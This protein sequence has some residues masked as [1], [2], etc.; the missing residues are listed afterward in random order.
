MNLRLRRAAPSM[1][2]FVAIAILAL[3]T[4]AE[5]WSQAY[6][7]TLNQRR[8]A[9]QL[10][11]EVWCKSQSASAPRLGEATLRI[12]YNSTYL[13][14]AD[15]TAADNNPDRTDSIRYDV[16]NLSSSS[17]TAAVVSI[18]SPFDP[19][20]SAPTS[21][22]DPT[23][24]T[25][26]PGVAEIQIRRATPLD[27]GVVPSMTGRG[28][29]V[30]KIVFDINAAFNGATSS[31]RDSATTFFSW[32][33]VGSVVYNYGGSLISSSDIVYTDPVRSLI[34]GLTIINPNGPSEVVDR[35]G[36]YFTEGIL[37]Y[38]IY[39]ER[40]GLSTVAT[41]TT[42]ATN[43]YGDEELAYYIDYRLSPA[44]SF[45][46]IGSID[47][48]GAV[49][50]TGTPL[51]EL[52][53]D[54]VPAWD[55]L[56]TQY[57]DIIDGVN[58]L[59]GTTNY[60]SYRHPLRAVWTANS[61][62]TYRSEQAQIRIRM[63]NGAGG[64]SGNA[65]SATYTAPGGDT[66]NY[67]FAIGR[68]FFQ[69]YSGNAQYMKTVDNYLNATEL[70]VEAWV[71]LNED[72]G[73]GTNPGIV[74]SGLGPG[75]DEGAWILYL[76]DGKYP[77]F[78]VREILGRDGGYLA[79]LV[80]SRS[81]N[82]TSDSAP[83]SATHSQNWHHIAATVSGNTVT[84]LVDGEIV[85]Y[86]QNTF[87]TNMRML[88]TTHPIWVGVNPNGAALTAGSYLH[89]GVKG[90]RV[91]RT[92]LL[93]T[94]IRE[95]VAGI[96]D[97]AGLAV[98]FTVTDLRKGLEY[99][100]D[101]EGRWNDLA[102]DA[103][104][105]NGT[106]TS[107][108]Y[109]N[110]STTS[111]PVFRP[112]QP[113]LRITAPT[114][115]AGVSNRS[116]QDFE[117]RWVGYGLGSVTG[118]GTPDGTEDLAIEFSHDGSTNWTLARGSAGALLADNLGY[119]TT[120]G[121]ATPVDIE[122]GSAV[123][124][125]Y[126]NN[127]LLPGTGFAGV[128]QNLQ[129]LGTGVYS[130]GGF[131]RIRGVNAFGQETINT[132][133][134][135]FSFA[136]YFSLQRTAASAYLKVPAG[137]DFNINSS[138]VMFEAWVRPYSFPASGSRYPI[139]AKVS[140]SG[141]IHYAVNLLST[142]QIEF[143]T[144][145]VNG[146]LHTA[147]S[148]STKPLVKPRTIADDSIWTHIAVSL[149]RSA[150]QS[151]IGFWIDGNLQSES[152][153]TNQLGLN[154]RVDSLNSF[155]AY[156]GYS[157]VSGGQRFIGE[158]REMRFWNGEPNGV[159]TADARR[160]YIQGAQSQRMGDLVP[161]TNLVAAF[162]MNGGGF[163]NGD[164]NNNKFNYT[165]PRTMNNVSSLRVEWFGTEITFV[166]AYPFMK[167]V[168]PT[169]NER[170]A[171]SVSDYRLR[172]V[173]FDYDDAS[174]TPGDNVLIIP[175]NLQ[176]SLGGGG[177]DFAQPFQ[178]VTSPYYA[179]LPDYGD[180]AGN[181][182][183]QGFRIVDVAGSVATGADYIFNA[184][185][186]A[187]RWNARN[188]DPDMNDDGVFADPGRISAVLTQARLRL[189]S[190]ISY[191]NNTGNDTIRAVSQ[192][193]TITPTSNFSVRV[194]LQGYHEGI[195][196]G[197]ATITPGPATA[198]RQLGS[199]YA[200][201]GLKIKLFSDVAGAP[202]VLI[203]SA[204]SNSLYH[205]NAF[206]NSAINVDLR[207]DANDGPLFAMVPFVFTS[208]PDGKY[209]VTVQHRNHL[210]AMS[211]IPAVFNYSGD[212]T[213]T[214]SL[215]SGWDFTYWDG[216]ITNVTS[217]ATSPNDP[218]IAN[219]ANRYS[220]YG[221]FSSSPIDPNWGITGLIYDEGRDGL[222]GVPLNYIGSMVAGDLN[223]DGWIDASDRVI[224]RN[225]IGSTLNLRSDVDG[226]NSVNASDRTIVDI[227]TGRRSSLYQI[228]PNLTGGANG[229]TPSGI[230]ANA[231]DAALFESMVSN[232]SAAL[233][234]GEAI[235]ERDGGLK[236]VKG[237]ERVLASN[238]KYTVSA[239]PKIVGDNVELP[240]YI[241]NQG[242]AFALANC[243]FTVKFNPDVLGFTSLTGS[244][245]VIF[246]NT[247]GKTHYQG[248]VSAPLE[249]TAVSRKDLRSI[250]ILFDAAVPTNKGVNVPNTKTYLGTLVFK[251]VRTDRPIN[252]TWD[253]VSVWTTTRQEV[254]GKGKFA[255]IPA[256][257]TYTASVVSPNGGERFA[258][259]KGRKTVITWNATSSAPVD[260]EFSQDG[261]NTW[262]RITV[263][264]IA[265]SVKQLNWTIPG[266]SSDKCLIRVVDSESG[267]EVDRSDATFVIAS[268]AAA[269]SRPSAADPIYVYGSTDNIK[270]SSQGV[271]KTRFEFKDMSKPESNWTAIT[272][273][274]NAGDGSVQWTVPANINT[275][276]AIIRMIDIESN[277]EIARTD[278]FKVLAG[279]VMFSYPKAGSAVKANGNERAR[280][281]VKN[282][283]VTFDLQF[284]A[285]GGTNWSTI[286]EKVNASKGVSDWTVPNKS[287]AK[288]ILRAI[289][290]YEPELEY[291]R[292]AEFAISGTTGVGEI[293]VGGL[294]FGAP[295]PN[296][297]NGIAT[298]SL[299]LPSPETVSLRVINTLGETVAVLASGEY[300]AAG[301]YNFTVSSGSLPAG[302]YT[303]RLDA[304]AIHLAQPLMIV[305]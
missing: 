55:G 168:E 159:T 85:D 283:V 273:Q 296:P 120:T 113:H 137:T 288:A 229:A 123:W 33:S 101:L 279:S 131:L 114:T 34:K 243:T 25:S 185:R 94:D 274:R 72:K 231:N 83:L 96:P 187:A 161:Q 67:G 136:P 119:I 91:W 197:N 106:Q 191:N 284:S 130:K 234:S 204:E 103:F 63:R 1:R 251:R 261:G 74:A 192:V 162:S 244:N 206:N 179:A 290:P 150:A 151:Q 98:P 24:G 248:I 42:I 221:N 250:E 240:M 182:A 256:I 2:L 18:Q 29:Y 170:I 143:Q 77:A 13:T 148:D 50:N 201:G 38:P 49:A 275:R 46:N 176:F 45:T 118:D 12:N 104:Y 62:Y 224:V 99:Y 36:T 252:F 125:P 271:N 31:I 4:V 304:G 157:P 211:R 9:D 180:G 57:G 167:I 215:E 183:N 144:T 88:T 92:A 186:Y 43:E 189:R 255:P 199:T 220:A 160:Q 295:V 164:N 235:I 232:V 27:T 115:G 93:Q 154:L 286:A 124:R 61:N 213:T 107:T 278:E 60:P 90:A 5:A 80:S 145:D 253:N 149:D 39:F 219:F 79:D 15:Y 132:T 258:S 66:S 267:V 202:G 272:Q 301:D 7:F 230:L 112:D 22:Q 262:E 298:L 73:T 245:N 237:G 56:L 122:S 294:V 3:A 223:Q 71:N 14:L 254:T 280:W 210:P 65:A 152:A 127:A 21:Y 228:M 269:I 11:V 47:E 172:W 259:N 117:V 297:A 158:L 10:W 241:V 147:V 209:W 20:G 268:L 184:Q 86:K 305:K 198:F 75:L 155:P 95:R 227:N 302:A 173:G 153:V 138:K 177:G 146:Q 76:K 68:L 195:E 270:W 171:N 266:V 247:D 89:A 102:T 110:G 174:F 141:T 121:E 140:D 222:S 128:A 238:V 28:S 8:R 129:N 188:T 40:S 242:D 216:G 193:F 44:A 225:E 263:S 257:L 181:E 78:K 175:P 26:L 19:Q 32:A 194:L 126:N 58:N 139:F 178:F 196:A 52:E 281:S 37:G 226:N 214:Y 233:A 207:T 81:I 303:I 156:L 212:D 51:D 166:P 299:A 17:Q 111:N 70:T 23:V 97:P 276:R 105:Q 53:P 59:S 54:G 208:V 264:P 82:V 205:A 142:G 265:A 300:L 165:I 109:N 246:R 84:L 133:T 6:E 203:D 200:T 169:F 289:Y 16:G 35:D 48:L 217:T 285:D 260:V 134:G 116:G 64:A 190:S 249:G 108:Y 163:V 135:R 277:E 87:A 293:E 287:T 41:I 236:A 100:T 69:Q 239:E 30:G 282:S 292:T 218:L 291:S